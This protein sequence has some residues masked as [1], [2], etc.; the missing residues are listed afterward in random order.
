MC[1]FSKAGIARVNQLDGILTLFCWK[2]N[3]ITL[4]NTSSASSLTFRYA[5]EK[6]IGEVMLYINGKKVD[7]LVFPNTTNRYLYFTEISFDIKVPKGALAMNQKKC[8]LHNK[9]IMVRRLYFEQY[10]NTIE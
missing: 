7:T 1:K 5:N 6:D 3:L 9:I 2:G 10:F 4:K 8:L